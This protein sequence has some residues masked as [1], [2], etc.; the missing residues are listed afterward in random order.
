MNFIKQCKAKDM[1]DVNL[2]KIDKKNWIVMPKYDGNYVQ[3][4]KIDN[5]V[6][7]FTSGVVS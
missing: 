6:R 3:I 5:I 1:S 4:H 2:S 7:F